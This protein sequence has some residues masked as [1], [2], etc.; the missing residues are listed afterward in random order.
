MLG[1]LA[2]FDF[3][4]LENFKKILKGVK[5]LKKQ[6]VCERKSTNFTRIKTIN[7]QGSLYCIK[8]VGGDSRT[9]WV[10]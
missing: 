2:N 1:T 8:C 7:F 3:G 5:S 4:I 10:A 9:T 6:E